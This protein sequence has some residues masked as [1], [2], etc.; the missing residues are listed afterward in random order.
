MTKSL[1][2]LLEES[3]DYAGMFPPASLPFEESAR[4]HGRY[5]AGPDAWMLGSFVCPAEKLEALYSLM[6]EQFERCPY[7]EFRITALLKGGETLGTFLESTR[8]DERS[9]AS[10]RF[11]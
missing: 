4:R 9:I 8:S 5:C 6:R 11:H 2:A 10:G 3:I 7:G 1:R